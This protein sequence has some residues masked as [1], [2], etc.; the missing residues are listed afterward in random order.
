MTPAH[1]ASETAGV[2]LLVNNLSPVSFVGPPNPSAGPPAA[3]SKSPT[4]PTM[5]HLALSA[6]IPLT[7]LHQLQIKRPTPLRGTEISA[8]PDSVITVLVRCPLR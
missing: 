8:G 6:K 2:C 1:H 4:E 3:S 7:L 5:D